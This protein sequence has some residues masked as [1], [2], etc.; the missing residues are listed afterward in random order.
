MQKLKKTI[1]DGTIFFDRERDKE[2]HAKYRQ[3]EQG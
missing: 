1:V 2:L 3:K